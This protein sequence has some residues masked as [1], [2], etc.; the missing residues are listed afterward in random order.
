MKCVVDKPLIFRLVA[1]R[2]LNFIIYLLVSKYLIALQ[3]IL[4]DSCTSFWMNFDLPQKLRLKLKRDCQF[5]I[6]ISFTNQE[7]T[8]HDFS[9]IGVCINKLN[10]FETPF[11][12]FY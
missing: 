12:E 4:S 3:K 8:N 7:N 5:A 1:I 2:S 11:Q 6:N 9:L 10:S